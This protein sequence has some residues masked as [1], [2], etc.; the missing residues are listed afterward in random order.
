M[1]RA[2]RKQGPEDIMEQRLSAF[3]D[4]LAAATE[5]IGAEYFQLPVADAGVVYR[6]RVY[7][8]ELYHQLRCLWDDF[9]LSLGGEIDK[10][11]NPHFLDG[12]Y[13]QVVPDFLVHSPG[14][15][16]LNL[17]CAEVKPSGRPA[18]EF[19]CDLRKLTWFCL[20]A[21]Y[22]RGIFLVYGERTQTQAEEQL[23]EKV[24]RA[25]GDAE[26]IDLTRIHVFSHSHSGQ[27]ARKIEL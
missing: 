21:D 20:G 10:R 22:Y 7:C 23:R 8:Y 26:G 11:G 27:R 17:A 15:M 1:R 2:R 25:A 6:E 12:P 19:T 3:E 9:P 14:H 16:D 24:L 5:R 18:A 13:A 4:M